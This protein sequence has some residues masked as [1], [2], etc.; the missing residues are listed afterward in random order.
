VTV[1]S[2]GGTQSWFVHGG[3]SYLSQSQIAP[4]FGLG[5]DDEVE[6]VVVLWPSGTVQRLE[7]PAVNRTLRAVEPP[8]P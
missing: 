3:G 5:S 7:S 1:R 6:T 4:T 8:P 2:A